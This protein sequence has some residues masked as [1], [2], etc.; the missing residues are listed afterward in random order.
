MFSMFELLR[1]AMVWMVLF[2]LFFSSTLFLVN[3]FYI[4]K[5]YGKIE[6]FTNS[7]VSLAQKNGGF[8]SIQ[9]DIEVDRHQRQRVSFNDWAEYNLKTILDLNTKID[10]IIETE[11]GSSAT[12]TYD[13]SVN[14]FVKPFNTLSSVFTQRLQRGDSF[15]IEVI[16]YYKRWNIVPISTKI[17]PG[18]S[19]I[20]EGKAHAYIK[21]EK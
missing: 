7:V 14:G 13:P 10:I 8:Y 19:I 3:H 1:K 5:E 17:I 16:P 2:I 12:A 11:T 20:K 21:V 4:Y 9:G 15:T 6:D 18:R